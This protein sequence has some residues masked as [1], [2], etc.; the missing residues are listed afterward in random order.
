MMAHYQT[1]STGTDLIGDYKPLEVTVWYNPNGIAN[2][3]SM[4]KLIHLNRAKIMHND[5]DDIFTATS[6]KNG[7]IFH[8][9]RNK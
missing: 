3:L 6:V 7:E 8:F 4:S 2:V 1:G 9:P 5:V